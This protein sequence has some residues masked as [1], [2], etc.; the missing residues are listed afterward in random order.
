MTKA[1]AQEAEQPVAETTKTEQQLQITKDDLIYLYQVLMNSSI[2][3]RDSLFVTKLQQKLE[4]ILN[5]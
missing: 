5:S 1:K 4:V 2:P 3:A